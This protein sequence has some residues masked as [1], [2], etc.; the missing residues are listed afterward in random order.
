MAVLTEMMTRLRD[1]IVSLRH[2]RLSFQDDL[3]RQ[4]AERRARVSA[5]CAAF[6]RDRAGAHR[7]W[8]GSTPSERRAASGHP[9][10]AK[11]QEAEPPATPKAQRAARPPVAPSP[12][13]RKKPFKGLRKH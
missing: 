1:E 5:M 10:R 9:A 8:F 7:A 2:V 3:L 11:A 4:T 12:R 6:A 13:A